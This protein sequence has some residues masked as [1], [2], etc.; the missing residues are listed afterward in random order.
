MPTLTYNIRILADEYFEELPLLEGVSIQKSIHRL[1][2]TA[3]IIVPALNKNMG[4]DTNTLFFQGNRIDIYLGYDE[5]NRLEFSGFIDKIHEDDTKITLDCVDWT[6]LLRKRVSDIGWDKPVSLREVVEH[7]ADISSAEVEIDPEL[8]N[9]SVNRHGIRRTNFPLGFNEFYIANKTGIS[10]LKMLKE[11][12]YMQ[13]YMRGNKI[14]V[15]RSHR[16]DSDI[17]GGAIHLDYKRSLIEKKYEDVSYRTHAFRVQVRNNTYS[18]KI[19][20]WEVGFEEGPFRLFYTRRMTSPSIRTIAFQIYNQ[21]SYDGVDGYVRSF[22]QPFCTYGY[23]MTY[24]NLPFG[25]PDQ[26]LFIDYV[27]VY[28]TKD[29]GRR[30]IGLSKDIRFLTPAGA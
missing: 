17:A 22:L 26:K 5:A 8:E 28:F 15:Y 9:T 29:G 19:S 27:N 18:H 23:H 25:V 30:T 21:R 2:D 16:Q 1:T 3:R 6:Y 11:L 4:L 14:Y 12:T 24:Q 10:V 20:R 7:V 13:F